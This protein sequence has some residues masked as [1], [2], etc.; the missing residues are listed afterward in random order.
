MRHEGKLEALAL[1]ALLFG[2]LGYIA[3][4]LVVP[5]FDKLKEG[6]EK[7]GAGIANAYL[8][9]ALPAPLQV[10]GKYILQDTGELLNPT[11]YPIT[12][13]DSSDPRAANYDGQLPTIRYAGKTYAL[14]PH[15]ERGNYPAV[16]V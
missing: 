3:Y 8:W 12:W 9:W 2:A 14:G 7:L 11:A 15:D 4:K 5:L 13:V 10:N 1:N 6:G 16:R